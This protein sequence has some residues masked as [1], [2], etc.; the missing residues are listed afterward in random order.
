MNWDNIEIKSF[1]SYRTN[2]KSIKKDRME[3]TLD[4]PIEDYVDFR[5][6]VEVPHV[7]RDRRSEDK[8]DPLD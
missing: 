7:L 2:H 1:K 4:M 5:K 8:T 3:V 6:Q